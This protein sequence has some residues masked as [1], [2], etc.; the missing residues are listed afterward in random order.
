M[1]DNLGAG[2]W[3]G[4]VRAAV[5][6]AMTRPIEYLA[7]TEPWRSR[8]LRA[9]Q[10]GSEAKMSSGSDAANNPRQIR[11]SVVIHR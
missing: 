9:R 1:A 11:H 7:E 6:Y 4:P 2:G 3:L 8:D 5:A 10:P